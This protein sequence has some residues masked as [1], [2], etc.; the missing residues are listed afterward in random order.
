MLPGPTLPTQA[1]QALSTQ[2]LL[3]LAQISQLLPMLL[4][5]AAQMPPRKH[6]LLLQEVD[7][8]VKHTNYFNIGR[9][10]HFSWGGGWAGGWL[11]GFV[12]SS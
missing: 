9:V 3:L 1:T 6:F 2:C 8:L 12:G 7:R 5:L 10:S 4:L 11:L